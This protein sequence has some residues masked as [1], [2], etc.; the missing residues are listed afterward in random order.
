MEVW[1]NFPPE[2]V[3]IEV[4]GDGNEDG[5][6]GPMDD[7]DD[8]EWWLNYYYFYKLYTLLN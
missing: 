7:D 2:P 8:E 1:P 4:D 6:G 3:I 5:D